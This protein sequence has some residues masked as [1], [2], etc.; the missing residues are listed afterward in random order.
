MRPVVNPVITL[1]FDLFIIGSA[2]VIL[3]GLAAEYQAH[4]TPVVGAKRHFL[5]AERRPTARPAARA[6]AAPERQSYRRSAA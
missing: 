4:R 6:G 3:A 5:A 2:V 1:L